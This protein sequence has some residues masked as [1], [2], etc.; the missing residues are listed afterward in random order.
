MYN[1]QNTHSK[2]WRVY[3]VYLRFFAF[4]VDSIIGIYMLLISIILILLRHQLTPAVS[5]F[6]LFQVFY[7]LNLSQYAIRLSA[8]VEMNMVSVERVLE[9]TDLPE[10]ASL[11]T[12][13]PNRQ[14]VRKG[15]IE[16]SSVDL[17]YSQGLPLALKEVSFIVRAGEKV[18]IV[19]RTGAGKSSITVALLRL[20]EVVSGSISIDG[21]NAIDMGVARF[22]RPDLHHTTEPSPV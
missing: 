2:C 13:V 5:A 21:V 22:E 6:V 20:V 11:H 10:E 16:F 4:Q 14:V 19:G 15:E 7:L 18:G 17:R 1:Y 12:S 3:F 9:Y 8:E